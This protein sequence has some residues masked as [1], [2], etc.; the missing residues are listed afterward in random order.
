M[1]T[2]ADIFS[3]TWSYILLGNAILTLF[4]LVLGIRN[5]VRIQKFT[6][7]YQAFMKAGFNEKNLEQLIDACIFQSQDA[8]VKN[9]AIQK[10]VNKMEADMLKCVQKIGVVKYSAFSDMGGDQSF[11]LALLDTLDNGIVMTGIY[12]RDNSAVYLK[13]IEGGQSRNV[14][15]TEEIQAMDKARKI[16]GQRVYTD[17]VKVERKPDKTKSLSV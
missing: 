15:T 17:S 12:A 13:S 1:N 6:K 2:P 3:Q 7:K 11:S 14:L 4:L 9:Q 5:T 8:L 10:M 16:F